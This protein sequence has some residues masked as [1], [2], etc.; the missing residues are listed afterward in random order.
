MNNTLRQYSLVQVFITMYCLFPFY[1]HNI[2]IIQTFS[3]YS[4]ALSFVVY[5]FFYKVRFVSRSGAITILASTTTFLIFL[6]MS[7]LIN[8]SSDM[9]FVYEQVFGFFKQLLLALVPFCLYFSF[10][11]DVINYAVHSILLL[12][13]RAISLYVFISVIFLIPEVRNYWIDIIY[14]SSDQNKELINSASYYTR[15]GLQ[16][17]SGF[18]HAILCAI[19]LIFSIYLFMC[20]YKKIKNYWMSVFLVCIGCFLYGRIAIAVILCITLISLFYLLCKFEKLYF[21]FIVCLCV[22][23]IV[24][25]VYMNIDYIQDSYSLAWIF[26]PLINFINEGQFTSHSTN[27][28]SSMYIMPNENTML[29]G[30]GKYTNHDGSYYMHTDVG[31]LRPV[32][33]GGIFFVFFYYMMLILPLILIIKNSGLERRNIL[34]LFLALALIVFELKGESFISFS[35]IIFSFIL[36]PIICKRLN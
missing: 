32:F 28:L 4:L 26:E 30:D 18:R 3:L 31:F 9:T 12:F 17:F 24:C 10:D 29:L 27:D 5:T 2:Y 33:F 36:I 35:A 8:L 16:G 15:F 25:V 11:S 13:I 22:G 19:A 21:I 6:F 20:G 1:F 14:F 7:M 34:T 23:T